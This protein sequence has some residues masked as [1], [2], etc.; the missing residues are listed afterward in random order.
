MCVWG[1]RC[2]N[3]AIA[4]H[5]DRRRNALAGNNP[6]DTVG[7]RAMD[8]ARLAGD[9][10][11]LVV[12]V[13]AFRRPRFHVRR[14]AAPLTSLGEWCNRHDELRR[15]RE[16]REDGKQPRTAGTGVFDRNGHSNNGTAECLRTLAPATIHLQTP[17]LSMYTNAHSCAHGIASTRDTVTHLPVV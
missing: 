3:G 15:Q 16:T 4:G 8:V 5:D 6:N 1:K 10:R 12:R 2:R 13:V 14:H 17:P 7:R 11:R 9:A